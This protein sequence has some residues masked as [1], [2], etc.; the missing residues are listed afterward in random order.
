MRSMDTRTSP[1][2]T[3]PEPATAT[4]AT[5][6]A[7]CDGAPKAPPE[8]D[9]L[10]TTVVGCLAELHPI[11]GDCN[12][13]QFSAAATKALHELTSA[14]QQKLATITASSGMGTEHGA[15]RA[16]QRKSGRS[17]REVNADNMATIIQ[18]LG[19]PNSTGKLARTGEIAVLVSQAVPRLYKLLEQQLMMRHN[20]HN[21]LARMQQRVGASRVEEQM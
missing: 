21:L 18:G 10:P 7:W 20:A 12:A 2:R 14:E 11:S 15:Q 3:W 16:R 9:T 1:A 8:G 6:G 17:R 5:G 4:D 13:T 19:G